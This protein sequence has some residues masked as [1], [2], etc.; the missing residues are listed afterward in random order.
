M[1]IGGL[2]EFQ[3]KKK[4]RKRDMSLTTYTCSL[5]EDKCQRCVAVCGGMDGVGK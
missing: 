1:P 5:V 2:Y 3:Q 4:G